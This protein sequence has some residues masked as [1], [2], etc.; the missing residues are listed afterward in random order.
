MF[1]DPVEYLR[2]ARAVESAWSALAG[3][4]AR[5]DAARPDVRTVTTA[6]TLAPALTVRG[7]HALP[8]DMIRTGEGVRDMTDTERATLAARPERVGTP[9][10]APGDTAPL[11]DTRRDGGMVRARPRKGARSGQTGPTVPVRLR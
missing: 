8:V 1:G 10:H 5:M 7:G 11:A 4:S 6:R 3:A 9:E 2:T